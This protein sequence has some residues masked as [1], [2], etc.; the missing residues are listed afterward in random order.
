[1]S[2]A[3]LYLAIVAIWA[4]VLIPRGFGKLRAR[5]FGSGGSRALGYR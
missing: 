3:I 1:M 4:C 5:G 2:S